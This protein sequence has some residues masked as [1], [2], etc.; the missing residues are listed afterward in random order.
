[1]KSPSLVKSIR[2]EGL[3][4]LGR[5]HEF[6][7]RYQ[8]S[9]WELLYLDIVASLY[10]RNHLAELL[11]ETAQFSH[12]PITAGGGVRSLEDAQTLLNH[13]A[14]IIALNTAALARPSLID[15]ASARYGAQALVLSVEAKRKGARWEA[16]GDCGRTPSG[17]DVVQ[18]CREGVDRGAGQILLTS[19][20]MDGT[21]SGFDTELIAAVA[22]KMEVPVIA[23][24]GAGTIEHIRAA[25]HA[26]ADGVAIGTALHYGVLTQETIEHGLAE[27]PRLPSLCRG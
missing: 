3:R 11:D 15:E 8:R 7:R 12:I 6:V 22:P 1:M 13:G 5:P 27:T 10:G 18:W 9:G 21:R 4:V 19:I 26:G 16:Y 17:R 23:G 24:G 14:D 20:D 25:K 2:M